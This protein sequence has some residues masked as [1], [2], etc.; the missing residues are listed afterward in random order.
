L[1]PADPEFT[2][3]NQVFNA[4]LQSARLRMAMPV[5]RL[6]AAALVFAAAVA[7][8]PRPDGPGA[9]IHYRF[10]VPEPQHRWMQVEAS[11]A[12]LGSAPLELRMSRSSP[13][14]YSLHDFAKN[15]YDVHAFGPDGREL[16]TTRPDASG[17]TVGEHGARVTVTYKVFGDRVDGTYLAIDTTHVH[18]NMPAAI[19]WAHGLADRPA[20]LVFEP[21]AGTRWQI[22]TQL[23][24]GSTPFEFTAPNLQYLMDS[25]VEFGPLVIR[26]FA[27]GSRIFRF[28]LHGEG[29]Q[30]DLD[31][32]LAD[33]EKI[34]R[35]EGGIYGEFPEY[36]PGTYTFLAD[37][38][39]YAQRDG[40]EHRNS[41]VMTA[42]ASIRNA[43]PELLDT[44]AHEF[45]HCWNVERI[46]PRS[47][48]P[49]DFD[50]ANMSAELWLAEGFTQYYGP[51]VLQRAGI[52]DLASMLAVLGDLVETVTLDPARL[53]RSA[54]E[55]S[56]M[57][58][59][60]DGGRPVDRTNWSN[61]VISYYPF[62]AAVALALDLSLRD[63]SNGATSLDDYMRALWQKYGRGAGSREGYVDRPYTLADAQATLAEV[64]GDAA[65][66]REFFARYVEGH[67][68]ADY[69]R[70]LAR[71]GLLLRR[72]DASRPWW[73]DLE[74][75]ERSGA[76][77]ITALVPSNTPASAAGLERDDE[78]RR[79]DGRRLVS[80][81]ELYAT[82]ARHRPGDRM[83]VTVAD[84]SGQERTTT[85]SLGNDPHL[86]VVPIEAASG[87]LTPEQRAF[88][89]RWLARR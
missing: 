2:I 48:E 5:R 88:R 73:G 71:A 1:I 62:G 17:W 72:R 31:G 60:I 83:E 9:A 54:E 76:V 18:M 69:R 13:G 70:L 51:L 82:I 46:R 75:D 64:S 43:R 32:Y 37:Y 68:L 66:A 61:T 22:A 78:L 30:A 77:R 40:M 89:D 6:L 8:A 55:A 25:P 42:A 12:E 65:F 3:L 20:T 39:P 80:A 33:V 23:H 24:P 7:G 50:R 29:A 86:E 34:V 26:Q 19:M 63:R 27:L 52:T 44:V 21:P 41:T 58:P 81:S 11:F 84:R 85:V 15:V 35:E 36:E 49:F 87:S 14:R 59:F 67:E 4:N 53:V 79:A 28:A 45:F 16:A 57:A 10:S 47:L 74:I 56:R 38:L